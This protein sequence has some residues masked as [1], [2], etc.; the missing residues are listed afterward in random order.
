MIMKLLSVG[1]AISALIISTLPANAE[2]NSCKNSAIT[3]AEREAVSIMQNMYSVQLK[4]EKVGVS[5]DELSHQKSAGY[6]S[7]DTASVSHYNDLVAKY[8]G[9]VKERN[10]LSDRYNQLK[11]SFNALTPEISP[12]SNHIFITCIN[13]EISV[14]DTN[15]VSINTDD[16]SRDIENLNH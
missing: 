12:S 1:I 2:P 6:D 9:V 8:N 7:S 11:D 4:L 3:P 5:L 10:Q 16:L 15:T 14:L 13:S